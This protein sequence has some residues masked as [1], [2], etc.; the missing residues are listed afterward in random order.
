LLAVLTLLPHVLGSA[1]NIAYNALR[2]VS[3]LTTEQQEVFAW[4]VLAYN[5]VM[6]PACLTILVGLVVPAWRT[7]RD[8]GYG[9]TAP[10]VRPD[11]DRV[12]AVRRRVLRWPLW[13]VA[14]SCLGWLPGGMVF[15]LAIAWLAGPVDGEVFGHFVVSFTLSGLIALTYSFFA[16]QF[17][18]LRVFY[19]RLWVDG[20]DFAEAARAELGSV[21]P[22]LRAF[23]LLAGVIPLAGAVLLIGVGPET[24]GYRTFRLLATA[25]IALG[26]AGFGLAAVAHNV[27]SQTLAVLTRA[28]GPPSARGVGSCS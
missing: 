21:A 27:L 26:M 15:P 10:G 7:W 18:A 17:M 23:Q 4:L 1:V 28:G 9:R 16:V 14:V 2:I 24:S 8:L 5:L 25:L 20:R 11:P 3:S 13:A 12:A 22:R 19:H 6:Y